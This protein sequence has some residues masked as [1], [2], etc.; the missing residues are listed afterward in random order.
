MIE[1]LEFYYY[2][3]DLKTKY[4]WQSSGWLSDQ[5]SQQYPEYELEVTITADPA[6][7]SKFNNNYKL[8]YDGLHDINGAK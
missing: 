4:L 3:F 6:L 8:G 1:Y 5:E 7:L 2:D